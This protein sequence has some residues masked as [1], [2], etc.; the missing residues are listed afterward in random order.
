MNRV[1]IIAAI[2]GRK[3][4]RLF[5]RVVG[6]LLVHVIWMPVFLRDPTKYAGILGQW[7]RKGLLPQ[8]SS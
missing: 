3:K 5:E 2:A 8:R 7:E 1:S 4:R 6:W